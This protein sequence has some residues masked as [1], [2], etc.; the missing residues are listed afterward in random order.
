[1]VLSFQV[2][3]LDCVFGCFVCIVP[4]VGTLVSKT[5]DK[6]FF[7]GIQT[8]YLLPFCSLRCLSTKAFFNLWQT[9]E[10]YQLAAVA[11][12]L[13]VAW[14]SL[15]TCSS[16]LF[17]VFAHLCLSNFQFMNPES[18]WLL[19]CSDKLGLSLELGSFAA[20]VMIS[21]T[22]LAQHTLEQVWIQVWPCRYT[23]PFFAHCSK[24]YSTI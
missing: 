4:Y 3:D 7:S 18:F 16:Y 10:L 24:I 23:F 1:M 5:Y 8:F 6:P 2:G 21:T 9:N 17:S 22:D 13:L 14:V 11:F 20:G 12:C 19:Q 15:T